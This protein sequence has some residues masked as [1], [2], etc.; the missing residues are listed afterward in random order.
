VNNELL[1]LSMWCLWLWKIWQLLN[2]KI[3]FDMLQ[4]MEKVIKFK[5]IG[6]SQRI[7]FT[8][9]RQHP[10]H[11]MWLQVVWFYV[12]ERSYLSE[13]CCWKD[14]MVKHGRTMCIIVRHVIF[15][16]C[17]AKLTHLWSLYMLVYGVCCVGSPQELPLC[18]FVTS[19]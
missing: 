19:V 14:E 15:Q 8:C 16:M 4:F 9:N 12:F 18:W 17:M 6:L 2:I 7:M 3:L 11:W 10:S 13:Y 1:C 5:F